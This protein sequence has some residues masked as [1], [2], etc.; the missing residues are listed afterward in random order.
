M[1][2]IYRHRL[3][4]ILALIKFLLPFVLQHP[5]YEL[6]RDEMLYIEQGNHLAWGFMEVPP[7]L[8]VFAKL[9]LLTGGSFFWIKFWPSLIGAVTVFIVCK[10]AA[11][12]GGKA[13]AQFVAGLC[14][15][16]GV[17]MR[18]HYLFQPNFLEIFFW[19][20]SAYFLIKYINTDKVKYIYCVSISLAL[21]WLSKYSV[22]FFAAGIFIGLLF[23]PQRK[24]FAS[25]H[26]YLAAL[27]AII[28]ISPNL[29]WQYNHKW[30]VVHH[31]KELRE[32]QLQYINP[33]DFLK[34]Q[35]L[36]HFPYFFIWI[37]GLLWLLFFSKGKPYKIL[38]F[39]YLTVIVLL[40][41]SNGKDYYTLGTYPMLFVAGGVWLEQITANK[42]YWLRFASITAIIIVFIPLIPVMLPVWKPQPLADYYKKTGLYKTGILKWEDLREHPLPQDFADM[43]SWSELGTKVSKVY[44]SLP[45]SVKNATLIYCSNYGLA[46]AVTYYGRG[47]PQITSDNASFL[48]WMPEKYAIKNLLFVGKKMPDKDDKVFQQFEKYSLRDSTTAPYARERGVKIILFENGNDTLNAMLE[49]GIKEMKDV[50]RR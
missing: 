16:A 50:Y 39:I 37:A 45:D 43:I 12:M 1:A 4:F 31:M 27:L 38:A 19:T 25:K 3:A 44:A 10:M 22:A 20:L 36:M 35:V 32:T 33:F 24:L 47:L 26:V 6:H 15:I 46:G 8:S 28:I 30:P 34:N 5:V 11:A 17:Y 9:A 18:V 23:T 42:A 2:F 29:L 41:A 49:A 7:L 13:F 40:V 14:V 48:F 21:G